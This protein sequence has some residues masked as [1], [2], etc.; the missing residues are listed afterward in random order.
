MRANPPRRPGRLTG[1]G[2]SYILE[3][4]TGRP[5]KLLQ[6]TDCHLFAD[7]EASLLGVPTEESLEAV[8]AAVAKDRFDFVLLTGDLTQDGSPEA[9]RRLRRRL[10]AMGAPWA[11]LPGNHDDPA[12]MADCLQEAGQPV[13][14][15]AVVGDWVVIL[16]DSTVPGSDAGRLGEGELARLDR[17]LAEHARRHALVALHHHPVDMGTAWLGPIGLDD[18]AAFQEVVRRHDNVRAVV[19]GHVHQAFE[20]QRDGRW[21]MSAPSTC[22]QFKPRTR[23]FALDEL[24]PGWRELELGADG[25]V[26]SRVGRV[27]DF[28]VTLDTAAGGY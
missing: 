6:I 24:P 16:L 11:W 23:E 19:W 15:E 27:R 8:L 18:G 7:P 14:R 1:P 13:A 21:W 12:A 25:G 2:G 9:Y 10:A 5:L 26:R 4:M 17:R 22:F 3:P 20:V 28:R